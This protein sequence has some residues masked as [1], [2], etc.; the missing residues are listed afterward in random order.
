MTVLMLAVFTVSV[1][2]GVVL[3][4]LPYLIE[5]LLGPGGRAAE[6]SRSTGLLTALYMF[7][8]FLFAPVWGRLSDRCGRR[9]IPLIGLAGFGTITLTFSF[10]ESLTG[11]YDGSQEAR[12]NGR[13]R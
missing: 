12:P 4:L 13:T 11:S 10:T 7:A 8:L 2:F 5:R 3:P 1:G 9:P 6:V